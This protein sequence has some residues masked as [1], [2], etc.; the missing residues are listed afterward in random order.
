MAVQYRPFGRLGFQVSALG[1]GCMRFPKTEAGRIDE[2]QTI[3]MLEYALDHGVNYLD[4]AHMYN[5]GDS[6][7]LL[8][9]V[10]AA[11]AG[12]GGQARV[13]VATKLPSWEPKAPSDLDRLLDEQLA[14]LQTDRIDVYLMHYLGRELWDGLKAVGVTRWLDR[15]LAEGRIG[16]AGFSF[17]DTFDVFHE[18]VD[19]YD[20]WSVC[21][22]QYNY[23]NETYQAGTRGLRYA[24]DKGLAVVVMEPL[25]GGR[26]ASAP[27]A[28]QRV[29][30]GAAPTRSPAE[31]GLQWLWNQ[32]EVSVV[33]SG[34]TTLPQV[35]ENVASAERSGVGRL[36]PA[37]AERI[38]RA[39]DAYTALCAVRCTACGY[40]MPC[41][42][43]V[44]IPRCFTILNGGLMYD[45]ADARSRYTRFYFAQ[46]D[47]ILGSSCVQCQECETKCP[48]HIPISAWM[49]YVHQVLGEG[50]SYDRRECPP[51]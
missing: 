41:P 7:R 14:R 10:L 31:W 9:R 43:G 33:L 20:G 1:F 49:P 51:G 38:A 6:E 48:Q 17:H 35:Q 32:P 16:A 8:G 36:A 27:A 37:D 46:T 50:R 15:M 26:L 12:R 4:T 45:M 44:D 42:N 19:A 23:M 3:P 11:R 34:M 39:R 25:L 29:W 24:A 13:R 30:D 21:Q 47:K 18:I 22:I 40:C 5:D 28:V 2:D